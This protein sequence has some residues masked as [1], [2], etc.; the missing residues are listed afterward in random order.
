MKVVVSIC[1]LGAFLAS[2]AVATGHRVY[3]FNGSEAAVQPWYPYHPGMRCQILFDRDK[4]D[5]AGKITEFEL[6]KSV[7]VATFENVKFYMCHTPL[8]ALTA[9]FVANYDGNTPRMV[10]SFATYQLPEVGGIYPIPMAEPF[11]YN[12]RDNLIVE[13]TWESGTGQKVFLLAGRLAAHQCYAYDDEAAAGTVQDLAYN[14][15]VHFNT[16]PGVAPAAFGRGRAL[17]R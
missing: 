16:Y 14:A 4:I 5:Y 8:S 1:A 11:D 17:V 15:L 9:N 2:C 6:E 10:A 12:N 7:H 3:V 13:I